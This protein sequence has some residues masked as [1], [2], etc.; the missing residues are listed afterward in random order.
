VT[1]FAARNACCADW[2]K[3]SGPF[4]ALFFFRQRLSFC[5]LS[6]YHER[7]TL[8]Y[9]RWAGPLDLIARMLNVNKILAP[10]GRVAARLPNYE[11]RPE[12]L[13]M[14]ESVAAS[15]GKGEHLMV[16]AGTGVGKSFAYLVPAILAVTERED[17]GNDDAPRRRIV[18]STHTISLQEQILSRDLPLLKSVIPR[19][20]SAVL[21]KGRHNYLSLRRLRQ[22]RK[23]AASLFHNEAEFD[24]LNQIKKWSDVTADGSRSDLGFQPSHNVWDEVASDNSNCLGRACPTYKDCFYYAARRRAKNAQILIVNHA[25]FFSDL[26]LRQ[27]G[28]SILPDYDAVIFDEAHTLEAVAGDHLGLKITSGQINYALNRLYNERTQKGVFVVHPD[29]AGQQAVVAAR[30]QADEFFHD[31]YHWQERLGTSNGR[32]HSPALV[33]DRLVNSLEKVAKIARGLA[34][35]LDDKSERQDVLSSQD[36][37][38]ALAG[39]I[40]TWCEQKIEDNVYWLDGFYNRSRRL[41]MTFSAAPI[42][43][44]PALQSQLFEPTRSVVLTSAT[45]AVGKDESFKFFRGR[46]GL[47]QCDTQQLGSPFD[48]QSQV[49]LVVV[50]GMRDPSQDKNLY[51]EQTARMVER[52]V[53]RT[54]GHA[55]VLFTS[56]GSLRRVANLIKPFLLEQNLALYAQSD[57]L[58]R[59]QMLEK[60]RENPRGVLMGVDSFWQG[61][62]VPGDALQNVIITKLPFSVPDHPLLEARLEAIRAGGGNPFF[63][64][65]LPEAA[66][67][68]RQGF[69]RL[70]R[71]AN[72]RGMVVL[73][74]PRLRTKPYGKV[75]LQSLPECEVVEEDPAGN[76]MV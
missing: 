65:Q 72:D 51:D 44:G 25:L 58:P 23:R 40:S 18:I 7:V 22:A 12:Q 66:I 20:F 14:A 59:S 62:D 26:S 4:A 64:Y 71:T 6:D 39:A 61:V 10:D 53:A 8:S 24:S 69:G 36:R 56:Y 27:I 11:H 16:E 45:L 57:D 33:A 32:V 35:Q 52:Y 50:H 34:H 2:A 42:E 70:I 74:D 43:V 19:E 13:A 37:M 30:I 29:A 17:T 5:P 38:T 49:K 41:Q 9:S 31:A 68:L 48:Y 3:Q 15:L 55:F 60:F 54:D 21:V 63:D 67:K 46:L 73:L 28:A 75:F 76:V 47:T 1:D